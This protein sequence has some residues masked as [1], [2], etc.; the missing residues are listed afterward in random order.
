[1]KLKKHIGGGTSIFDEIAE[2]DLIIAFF[3]CIRFEV[4]MIMWFKGTSYSEKGWDI[5]HKLEQSM[6]YHQELNGLYATIT[7]L[8]IVC[9]EKGLQL[10]IENPYSDQHY[11]TRYWPLD[12][13]LIDKDR[14]ERGDY[15]KKPTQYWFVNRMPKCN[16][17][18]EPLDWC[19]RK[20]IEY[21]K[22]ENGKSTTVMRSMIHPQYANRFI[23]EFILEEK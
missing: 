22:A 6:K 1:M 18:F 3:P 13:K 11:L 8:V 20:R 9:I 5:R 19:E 17:I 12:P 7:K 4:Q 16:L 23:R 21:V 15:Y 10:I 2:D 14:T